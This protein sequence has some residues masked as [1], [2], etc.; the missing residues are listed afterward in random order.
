LAL[1]LGATVNASHAMAQEG[2]PELDR[3]EARPFSLAGQ[4]GLASPGGLF[5]VEAE[6]ALQRWLVLGG[7]AGPTLLGDANGWG[8]QG[9]AWLAPRLALTSVAFGVDLG[10]SAGPYATQAFL[11]EHG[12]WSRYDTAGWFNAAAR[13]QYL[14]QSGFSFRAFLGAATLLNPNS[15]WCGTGT[16][17]TQC[18]RKVLGYGGVAFGYAFELGANVLEEDL[19][20]QADEHEAPGHV[21][22]LAK[23]RAEAAPGK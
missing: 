19:G 20:A 2:R 3:W 7:G 22:T 10:A 4:L 23:H 6:Y 13:F 1:L 12:D 21:Q 14:S 9:G 16:E 18:R 17:D 5:G 15:G 8:F 11:D